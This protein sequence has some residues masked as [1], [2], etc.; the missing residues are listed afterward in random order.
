MDD[1]D[2]GLKISPGNDSSGKWTDYFEEHDGIWI[3]SGLVVS[4]AKHYY[5]HERGSVRGASA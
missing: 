2:R 3:A 4:T 5:P 1:G